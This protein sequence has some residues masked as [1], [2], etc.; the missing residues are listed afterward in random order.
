MNTKLS[1]LLA[2][3][4]VAGAANAVTF[5]FQSNGTSSMAGPIVTVNNPNLTQYN[6]GT[7]AGYTFSSLGYSY[8][9]TF[10]GNSRDGSIAGTGTLTLKNPANALGTFTFNFSGSAKRGFSDG[11]NNTL[12]TI[13]FSNLSFTLT[14]ASGFAIGGTGTGTIQILQKAGFDRSQFMVHVRRALTVLT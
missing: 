1:V 13:S 7:T 3:L 6:P 5:N 11:V 10:V 9:P 12:N 8:T 2:A 4:T 14:G